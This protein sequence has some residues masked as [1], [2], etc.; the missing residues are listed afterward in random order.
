M[1]TALRSE[2]SKVIT[3]PIDSVNLREQVAASAAVDCCS[4][5]GLIRW[6]VSLIVA[7]T[8]GKGHQR[9]LY[10]EPGDRRLLTHCGR[11][12]FVLDVFGGDIV[13]RSA[14]TGLAV[15]RLARIERTLS[16]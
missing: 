16:D 7:S 4:G 6:P 3:S 11:L 13:H 14:Y 9:K 15:N 8:S 5:R 12:L 10:R 2:D 1:R